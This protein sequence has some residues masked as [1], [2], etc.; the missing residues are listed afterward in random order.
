[1]CTTNRTYSLQVKHRT[2]CPPAHCARL[3]HSPTLPPPKTRRR[4]P[5]P[6]PTHAFRARRRQ[7]TAPS[8]HRPGTT[9]TLSKSR[10]WHGRHPG[11]L[12]GR[13]VLVSK[14]R[15]TKQ[16]SM[17]SRGKHQ[18]LQITF[19]P[20]CPTGS[21]RATS[22][23]RWR[24][25]RRDMSVLA[26]RSSPPLGGFDDDQ[27]LSATMVRSWVQTVSQHAMLASAGRMTESSGGVRSNQ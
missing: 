2:G 6:Q 9:D 24:R 19:P 16:S 14:Q 10:S 22:R 12:K 1:M 4:R 25:S 23:Q 5:P 17:A 26:R 20:N 7:R 3:P 8:S 15:V 21:P 27:S 18:R 13:G 11:C